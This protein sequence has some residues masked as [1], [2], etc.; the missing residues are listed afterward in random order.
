ME[1]LDDFSTRLSKSVGCYNH[2][3]RSDRYSLKKYNSNERLK[4]GVFAWIEERKRTKSFEISTYKKYGDQCSVTDKAD[5]IVP[6]M[7]YISKK[8]DD[9]EGTGIVFFVKNGSADV[10][11]DKMVKALK[12][13]LSLLY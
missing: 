13:I 1:T 6:G 9:G 8:K 3:C 4:M 10:D 7:H 12:A 11:F 2:K 5:K